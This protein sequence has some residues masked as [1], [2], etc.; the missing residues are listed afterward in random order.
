MYLFTLSKLPRFGV[1][2]TEHCVKLLWVKVPLPPGSLVTLGLGIVGMVKLRF[3]PKRIQH[4]QHAPL[5]LNKD[6]SVNSCSIPKTKA[7]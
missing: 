5:M 6:K 2:L 4:P 1:L 7:V 3:C